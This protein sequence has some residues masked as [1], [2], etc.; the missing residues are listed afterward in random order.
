MSG[1]GG[2]DDGCCEKNVDQPGKNRHTLPSAASPLFPSE[3]FNFHFLHDL[4][5]QTSFTPANGPCTRVGASA[6]LSLLSE[7]E[8]LPDVLDPFFPTDD[9]DTPST[10]SSAHPETVSAFAKLEFPD[11]EY[12]LK[13]HKATLGRGNGLPKVLLV[14]HSPESPPADFFDS[15]TQ[16][17]RKRKRNTDDVDFMVA[18]DDY[19][20]SPAKSP[21]PGGLGG[22]QEMESTPDPDGIDGERINV[23][24]PAD[25]NGELIQPNAISRRHL[26]IV[27]DTETRSWAMQIF[28]RNGLF[29]NGEFY[30]SNS[31]TSLQDGDCIMLKALEFRFFD[32]T[33]NRYDGRSDSDEEDDEVSNS[34]LLYSGSENEVSYDSLDSCDIVDSWPQLCSTSMASL[35]CIY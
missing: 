24:P 2:D 16:T 32:L 25:S 17:S 20:D 23:W 18:D 7:M 10:Y 13:A 19:G 35:N 34:G 29:I 28:G 31:T 3:T 21:F 11:T 22:G 1:G 26:Q 6:P 27:W 12:Y 8:V 5:S 4:S 15:T 33:C 9:D 30:P 14:S